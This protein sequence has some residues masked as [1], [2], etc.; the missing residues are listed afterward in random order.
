VKLTLTGPGGPMTTTTD[1]NGVYSFNNLCPGQYTVTVDLSTLP[2]GFVPSP[3]DNAQGN[4]LN[5]NCSPTPVMLPTP[6]GDT[7]DNTIDF[8]FTKV[9]Q[10]CSGPGSISSG[11]NG[12]A[13]TG[14]GTNPGYLWFNSNFNLKN[15]KEGDQVYLTNSVVTINGT[16]YNVPNAV[17]TFTSK[18]GGC[19]TTS[20]SNGVWNT[21]VPLAG[22]DEIFLSG[23]V[24]PLTTTLP[25]GAQV[26]WSGNIST[27][28]PG[29]CIQWKWGA[30]SYQPWPL[31]NGSPD[32]NA[33]Q[34]DA[35]HDCG[36]NHAGTPL[37]PTVQKA[38]R[39]GARGGGGSNYTGSWSSTQSVCPV[40]K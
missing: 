13:V 8:G 38:V 26:A 4:A 39:G 12:T 36:S 19:A 29:V 17:I 27:N 22:S 34:I 5:S 31:L 2:P 30:A 33:A 20:F 35:G 21:F 9:P 10:P 16:P 18:M 24:V 15:R 6:G 23:L 1:A 37:N 14:T 28:M 25:G 7:W 32:Y 3:C 40:C 11:F